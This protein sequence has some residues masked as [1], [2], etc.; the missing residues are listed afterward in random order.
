M[1]CSTCQ[2]HQEVG[3]GRA[4]LMGVYNCSTVYDIIMKSMLLSV[5][6]WFGD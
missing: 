2:L 4:M 3:G 1:V 6:V 5:L